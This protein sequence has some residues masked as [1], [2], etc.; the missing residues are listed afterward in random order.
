M[1]LKR[2]MTKIQFWIV[3]F[4]VIRLIGIT[5]PPLEKSHNWRQASG[6]MIA[7][8]FLEV[9]NSIL[10]PRKDDHK[11][12][13]GIVGIEFPIHN[14]L[15]YIVSEAFGYTH[16]YGRLINLIISSLGLYFFYLLIR[17][18]LNERLAFYS[19]YILMVSIWFSF[20]R[21]MMPDTFSIS[22]VFIGLYYGLR[23]LEESKNRNLLFYFFF[24]TLGILAKVPAS[25]YLVIL[26]IPFF[27]KPIFT[28]SKGKLVIAS[29][30][31]IGCVYW[32]YF[33]W[34]LHLSRTFGIWHNAGTSMHQGFIALIHHYLETLEKFYFSAFQGF[35]FFALF[36][37]GLVMAIKQRNKT[38]LFV[39]GLVVIPFVLFTLKTGNIFYHHN[40]YS[41]PIAPLMAIFAA[42]GLI[43][44][45]K[46][47]YV[48]ILLFVG[49]LESL[50]NQIHDFRIP[51]KE[52]YKL[53]LES[54]MDNTVPS[55]DWI[56]L[57]HSD[58]NHQIMYLSHR[59][60]WLVSNAELEDSLAFD[61]MV[62]W[63]AKY[64]VLDKHEEK[65]KP[66]THQTIFEN[67]D[68]KVMKINVK[69]DF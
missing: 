55:N 19:A 66:L 50:A 16:W 41:I 30:L 9:N 20:S 60:G 12:L 21:K 38:L 4:F 35:I 34:Y 29:L 43:Y 7:R 3:F 17:L 23:Y 24:A 14:Y 1:Q 54:I 31:I 68:F 67:A 45:N 42:F 28:L 26:A 25:I 40:Y 69:Q 32:W 51:A 36:L 63:G 8:N 39:F 62:R 46:T 49:C 52:R 48:L 65:I 37:F 18:L 56:I 27:T 53:T 22:L 47:K 58:E 57:N 64:I 61:K 2:M 5:N 59:K 15:H 10:Y 6:L 33:D 44:I 13:L 11:G